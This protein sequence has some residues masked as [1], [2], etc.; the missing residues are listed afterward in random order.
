MTHGNQQ[1]TVGVDDLSLQPKPGVMVSWSWFL[2]S[3]VG[4]FGDG[5]RLT[6]RDGDLHSWGHSYLPW[7]HNWAANR[8]AMQPWQ[9]THDRNFH[10]SP[11]I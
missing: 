5:G 8:F 3:E 9:L 4:R 10:H 11:V 6:A 2:H 7:G 1:Y